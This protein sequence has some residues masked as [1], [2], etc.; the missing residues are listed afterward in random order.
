ML[1]RFLQ[2]QRAVFVGALDGVAGNGISAAARKTGFRVN[3]IQFL[4]YE[5]LQGFHNRA[6]RIHCLQ[7]PVE[8]G[9]Q[10]ILLEFAVIPSSYIAHQ[11]ARVVSRG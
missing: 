7:W 9:L 6:W 3:E 10:G 4:A 1:D 11:E 2:I 8:E 5:R